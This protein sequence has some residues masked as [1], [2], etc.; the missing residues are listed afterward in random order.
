MKDFSTLTAIP[1]SDEAIRLLRGQNVRLVSITIGV[2]PGA[3]ADFAGEWAAVRATW[4]GRSRDDLRAHPVAAAYIALYGALGINANKMP[5]SA[6]NLVNRFAIG[7]GADKAIPRIHP[8]VDAGNVVQ[9]ET[10]MPVAVFDA[11]AIDGALLFDASRPDDVFTG[12][13]FTSPEAVQAG[14]LVLRD[15]SKVISEFCYRDC[16]ATAV[17]AGTMRLCV[18]I[19]VAPSLDDQKAQSAMR[20]LVDLISRVA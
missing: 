4:R 7:N 14:R 11:D 16:Q 13:G 20:R 17:T 6:V 18:V 9:A 3:T 15:S 8:A 1:H 10:L 12:F 5:P 19:P 2:S